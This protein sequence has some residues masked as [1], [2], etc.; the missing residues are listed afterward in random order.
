MLVTST[1]NISAALAEI[2]PTFELQQQHRQPG[3]RTGQ[4]PQP[5]RAGLGEQDLGGS[6]VLSSKASSNHS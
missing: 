5:A 1:R 6:D 3:H 2:S 4:Q